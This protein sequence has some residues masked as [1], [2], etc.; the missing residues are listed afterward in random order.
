MISSSSLIEYDTIPVTD[1]GGDLAF[2]ETVFSVVGQVRERAAVERGTK[3][4]RWIGLIAVLL[5]GVLIIRLGY[6][7][8]ALGTNLRILAEGN[9]LRERVVLSPRGEIVDRFGTVLA[10][11]RP[12]FRLVITPLDVP[13]DQLPT[14]LD[15]VSNLLGLQLNQ[16]E[17]LLKKFDPRSIQS[18]VVAQNLTNEQAILFE[19]HADE[20]SGLSVQAVPIREYV[21]PLAFAHALGTTGILSEQDPAFGDP[22]YDPGDA[23]GKTGLE[24]Q[25]EKELKGRNGRDMVEV[26]A[27]GS[28]VKSLGEIA[29]APGNSLEVNIDAGLQ[30]ALFDQFTARS[31]LKGAAVALDVKTGAVLALLSYPGFNG[32]LFAEGISVSEY[33]KLLQDPL[34]PLFNRA[35]GAQLP[36]GSTVKPMVALAAL[37]EGVVHDRTVIVDSGKISVPNQFTPG[38]VYDYVGWKRT[39]LGPMTARSAIAMSSDIYFYVVG[40][41]YE[42]TGIEGLGIDKLSEY[43]RRFNLGKITGIDLPGE[44][45]GLVADPAWKAEYYK[46]NQI[47]NRWYLGNTY[48]VSIGQGDMLVTPLQV[49]LWTAT[50]ANNGVGMK[51]YVVAKITRPDGAVVHEVVPSVLIPRLGNDAN[52]AVVQEGMRD[53]VLDGTAKRMQ[54][55][56]ISSAGKTGTAQFDNN[57]KEHAWFTAYA[58]YENPEIAITVIVEGGGEGG[59]AALP[60][61]QEGLRWWAEHRYKK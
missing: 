10:R 23:V 14:L 31:G 43:Y 32:N 27:L 15:R 33:Q 6:L 2:E 19:T 1:G 42:A 26:D 40:G 34:L 4:A 37:E 45:P 8:L 41:G 5:L 9:R 12:S 46:G 24:A 54:D 3:G 7:Q 56:P 25:Y 35:V 49:A 36:P 50:I 30:Q 20:Y 51:P 52:L 17:Q 55:L 48:H 44:K 16:R 28:V 11:S 21:Y 59:A 13:R 57:E 18:L 61:A 60:I 39:G 29:A 22:T 53:A 38:V 47:M 58:P